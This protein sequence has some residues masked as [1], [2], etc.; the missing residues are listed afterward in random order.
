MRALATNEKA[1]KA[2]RPFDSKRNGFVI[3]EGAGAII[4]EDFD[5]ARKR[6]AKIYA[7]IRGFGN[8]GEGYHW[9]RPSPDAFGAITSM[10]NA[11]ENSNLLPEHV[12]YINAHAT[13]TPA[14]SFLLNLFYF[15]FW[16]I[17][18]YFKLFAHFIMII[19]Y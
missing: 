9:S 2:S 19:N 18:I 13:S 4:L 5:H 17:F 15:I 11:I 12:D 8:A 16:H 3:G 7:E 10:K 6:G 1:S 14:G